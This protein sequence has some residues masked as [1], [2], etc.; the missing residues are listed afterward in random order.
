MC[1]VGVAVPH[2]CPRLY[3][4]LKTNLIDQ[5][6][7][8]VTVDM[9]VGLK[10][11][12]FN[13]THKLA[14]GLVPSSQCGHTADHKHTLQL[15]QHGV[16]DL[17][18]ALENTS[19]RCFEVADMGSLRKPACPLKTTWPKRH[20]WTGQ[21]QSWS[22]CLDM[23]KASAMPYDAILKAR[24]DLWWRHAVDAKMFDFRQHTYA[25]DFS[26]WETSVR[27]RARPTDWFFAIP[28]R[29]S[30]DVLGIY[31]RYQ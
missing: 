18:H 13:S 3:A 14:A 7:Q 8:I 27:G 9:F 25:L 11:G 16:D 10:V 23:V 29:V 15:Q 24:P 17:R 1:V 12:C 28:W 20:D 19:L 2:H 5:L 22:W 21:L 30:Q 31:H 6:S 4:D 26:K